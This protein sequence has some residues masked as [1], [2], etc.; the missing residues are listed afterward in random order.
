MQK[1]IYRVAPIPPLPNTR[2]FT[3]LD[4]HIRQ[5]RGLIGPIIHKWAIH[6]YSRRLD[7]KAI[8]NS[9][10]VPSSPPFERALHLLLH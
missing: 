4:N 6:Q 9:T 1:I 8:A 10:P 7:R 2:K 3:Q 5:S